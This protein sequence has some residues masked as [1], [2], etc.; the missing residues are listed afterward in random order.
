MKMRNWN[1]S[2]KRLI[3]FAEMKLQEWNASLR[4]QNWNANIRLQKWNYEIEML[5]YETEKC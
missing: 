3:Y 2:K 5:I 4:L 1:E